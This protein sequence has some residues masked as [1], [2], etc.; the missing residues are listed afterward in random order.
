MHPKA[1]TLPELLIGVTISALI[2]SVG[3][4]FLGS[5]IENAFRIRKT[6]EQTDS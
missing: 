2:M 5:G 6:L 1:F 4:I 3:A